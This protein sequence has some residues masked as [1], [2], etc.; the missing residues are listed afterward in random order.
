MLSIKHRLAKTTDIAAVN[1]HGRR[2]FN[3]L[4]VIK[5]LPVKTDIVRFAFVVS[6]K[7]S[8]KAVIRN[9]IRRVLREQV[10]AYQKDF[11][12]GDYIVIVNIKAVPLS[13][14]ELR[15]NFQQFLKKVN[16]LH[17]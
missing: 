3:N 5:H 6:T 11:K 14:S 17:R 16:L 1:K 13:N 15:E 9:R 4:F 12:P 7:V 8:K 10:R 2:F